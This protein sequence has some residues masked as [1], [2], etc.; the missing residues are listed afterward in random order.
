MKAEVRFIRFRGALPPKI[1]KTKCT[2][3]DKKCSY[4]PT[5]VQFRR[6]PGAV[7]PTHSPV[8]KCLKPRRTKALRPMDEMGLT[9]F[10]TLLFNLINT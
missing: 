6:Q 8:D 2:C 9:F 4:A 3:A 10:L 5:A 7:P 1:S